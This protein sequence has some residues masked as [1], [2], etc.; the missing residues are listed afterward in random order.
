MLIYAPI[1]VVLLYE[2]AYLPARLD[3]V[4]GR[5]VAPRWYAA[6]ARLAPVRWLVWLLA[7]GALAWTAS[8]LSPPRFGDSWSLPWTAAVYTAFPGGFVAFVL[9]LE[10]GDLK[11]GFEPSRWRRALASMRSVFPLAL[12]AAV[13]VYFAM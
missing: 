12:Y 2:L 11:R 8:L 9:T 1:A 13:V 7:A 3:W 10:F 5:P 4:L 6:A